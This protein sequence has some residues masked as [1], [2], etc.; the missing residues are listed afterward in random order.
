LQDNI[1][2]TKSKENK[3]SKAIKNKDK[4][5][6]KSGIFDNLNIKNYLDIKMN[7]KY[8]K[9]KLTINNTET[10]LNSLIKVN[11]KKRKE[12]YASSKNNIYNK[13]KIFNDYKMRT[14]TEINPKIISEANHKNK[15]SSDNHFYN[16]ISQ[17]NFYNNKIS[18]IILIQNFWRKYLSLRRNIDNKNYLNVIYKA[19]A[20]KFLIKVKMVIYSHL[21]KLLKYMIYNINYYLKYWHNKIYLEKILHNIISIKRQNCYKNITIKIPNFSKYRKHRTSTRQ[22]S[23]S[24]N[25]FKKLKTY[26][27]NCSNI[28]NNASST[29]NCLKIKKNNTIIK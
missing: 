8:R 13:N 6:I 4:R 16:L 26:Y 14:K 27:D 24:F 25:R 22:M 23:S 18:E 19:K 20:K 5:L 12:K 10:K 28:S 7:D 3:R 15:N 2:R 11:V 17:E 21:L 29:D 9:N 1:I